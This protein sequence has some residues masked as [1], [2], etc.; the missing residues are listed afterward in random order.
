MY[1][2]WNDFNIGHGAPIR[3][4]TPHAITG[5]AWHSPIS[6]N[7]SF[8]RDVQITGDKVTGDV[9]VA[10]M[11]ENGGNGFPHNRQQPHLS[12]PPTAVTLG[13]TPTLGPPSKARAARDSGYF[14][15]HVP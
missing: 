10:G 5:I 9:Y 15:L 4:S 8:V 3:S 6:V 11:D 14:C 13:P 12:D 1:I 7:P 2:S